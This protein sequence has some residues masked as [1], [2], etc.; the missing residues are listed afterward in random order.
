VRHD[1]VGI[2]VA[3]GRNGLEVGIFVAFAHS[4]SFLDNLAKSRFFLGRGSDRSFG[5]R[6]FRSTLRDIGFGRRRESGKRVAIWVAR[7][8][9]KR[10]LSPG[11]LKLVF[12]IRYA[13]AEFL[14]LAE[15]TFRRRLVKSR[16]A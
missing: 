11:F 15:I 6:G 13:L 7:A 4:L 2:G 9:R 16:R 5:G 10:E 12:K 8:E 1:V 14:L 3:F